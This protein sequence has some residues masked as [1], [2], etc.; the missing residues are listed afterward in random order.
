[1]SRGFVRVLSIQGYVWGNMKNKKIRRGIKRTVVLIAAALILAVAGLIIKQVIKDG[2]INDDYSSVYLN[3]K[4]QASVTAE[5]IELVEQQVSCG[6]AC[7]QMIAQWLGEEATE[8]SMLEANDGRIS[9]ALGS[10]FCDEMNAQIQAYTT[11]Q[12]T[13]LKNTELI[14]R[15][16][17][18][19]AAGLP[20]PVGLAAVFK[21]GDTA[22][23]TLHYAVVTGMDILGDSITV[24]NPYGY[25]EDYSVEEFLKATRYD[26]YEDMELSLWFGFATGF[27]DKNTIYTM[28]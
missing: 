6:Y 20:V 9:T 14:D 27:F 5:G 12:H 21:D 28:H 8:H 3:E 24:L 10:G 26:S 22:Y 4:Y 17:E 25:V 2:Y 7:I 18:S 11:T 16:Y 1:M 23:W 15:I 19:L 13:Y